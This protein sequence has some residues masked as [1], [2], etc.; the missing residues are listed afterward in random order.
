LQQAPKT[1]GKIKWATYLQ[2]TT[3]SSAAYESM[4]Y[5]G[6]ESDD[7]IH[8]I[9]ENKPSGKTAEKIRDVFPHVVDGGYIPVPL[10]ERPYNVANGKKT[11][12]E[13]AYGKIK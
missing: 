8:F 10:I 2:G 6:F 9:L 1:I 13:R 11:Y 5:R 12:R 7:V 3:V 4:I